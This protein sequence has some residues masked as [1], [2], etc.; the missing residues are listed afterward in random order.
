M[1]DARSGPP[2]RVFLDVPAFDWLWILALS[3][4]RA[5]ISGRIGLGVDEAHYALYGM[6]LDWSY[7]DHP[8]L[9]GWAQG[10]YLHAFGPGELP[11][12]LP[13]IT[14]GIFSTVL[15][16]RLALRIC[17]GRTAARA[18]ALALNASFLIAALWMMFLPDTLLAPLALWLTDIGARVI[19]RDR[20]RDWI[21]LGVCLG[22]S[23]LAKYTAI[24]FV[25]SLLGFVATERAWKSVRPMRLAGAALI[26]ALLVSPVLLWNRAHDWISFKYQSGHVLGGAGLYPSKFFLFIAGQL[27]AYSPFLIAAAAIGWMAAWRGGANEPLDRGARLRLRL[28]LWIAAPLLAFFAYASFRDEVL[29]HWTLAAWTLLIPLGVALALKLGWRRTAIGALAATGALTLFLMA[30]LVGRFLPFPDWQSPYADLTGWTEIHRDIAQL[31]AESP[32]RSFSIAVPNW[33]LGSRANYYLSDL[34]PVFVFDDRFDQFD[35]WEGGPPRTPDLLILSWRGFAL[36]ERERRQ[37]DRLAP[38]SKRTF[39]SH[40]RAVNQASLDWCL[41]FHPR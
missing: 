9:V 28:A 16:Y 5:T 30:E 6:R 2:R 10:L 1:T 37:C 21:E 12:R 19:E 36:G 11:A 31:R 34:A 41:G 3:A 24:L 14:C 39:Y 35:L 23:G 25:A 32:A 18:A 13:A 29:L 20:R 17:G 27:A 15:V 33:T 26:A 38:A 40:G 7:F 22:L 8:P 4:W